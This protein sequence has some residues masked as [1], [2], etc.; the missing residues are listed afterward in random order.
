MVYIRKAPV[1]SWRIVIA[2]TAAGWLLNLT[3]RSK[4]EWGNIY[5]T[6]QQLLWHGTTQIVTIFAVIDCYW[7]KFPFTDQSARPFLAL[8]IS[9]LY[10][11]AV[12][13][14]HPV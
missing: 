12:S 11:L 2:V 14:V 5:E 9:G 3:W 10:W 7:R 1:S 6:G 4:K 13:N 8:F